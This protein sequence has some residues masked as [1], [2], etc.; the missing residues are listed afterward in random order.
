MTFS[1]RNINRSVASPQHPPAENA[2]KLI[3]R[4]LKMK[5]LSKPPA[6]THQLFQL[7][8]TLPDCPDLIASK[9]FSYSV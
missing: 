8:I 1:P 4:H 3:D 7:R 5:G 2:R 6:P 9:P